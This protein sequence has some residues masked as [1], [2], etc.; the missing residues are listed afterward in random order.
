MLA[1]LAT[2]YGK[3]RGLAVVDADSGRLLASRGEHIPLDGLDPDEPGSRLVG[4]A[5]G[6][7][8]LVSAAR[9]ERADGTRQLIVA[10]GPLRLPDQ[11]GGRSAYVTDAQG[12]TV[13]ASGPHAADAGLRKAVQ[14]GR[15]DVR[16]AGHRYYVIGRGEVPAGPHVRDLGLTVSTVV[17]VPA[18]TAVGDDRLRGLGAAGALL[19]VALLVTW[20]LVRYVQRPL[21]TLH[22]EARR[23]A[24]GELARPVSVRARGEAARIAGALESLRR[25][26]RG[27]TA[28][29]VRALKGRGE[30]RDQPQRSRRQKTAYRST[31]RLVLAGCATLIATWAV[32]LPLAGHGQGGQYVPPQAA[33]DQRDRTQ[34]AAD[35]IRRTLGE[36]VADLTSIAKLTAGTRVGDVLD[37]ARPR[38]GAWRSLYLVN[39]DGRILARSGHHPLDI[40]RRSALAK[41]KPGGTAVLQLNRSG[42]VPV[43]AAV[44]P[45]GDGTRKLV[46]ELTPD[47]FNGVLTRSGLGRS[48]LVDPS[49][50]IIAS[51][52]GF[53]AFRSPPA[54]GGR[55]LAATAQV[56]GAKA[57]EG[58]GWRVVTHKPLSWTRLAAYE[59]ERHAE[60]AALLALAAAGLGLG[61]LELTVLR[62]LRALDRSAQALAG[63]DRTAVIYPVHH[64][65][66]GSVARSLELIRQQLA[67]APAPEPPLPPPPADR[68][69]RPEAHREAREAHREAGSWSS[70]SAFSS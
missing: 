23:V 29:S 68:D 14:D 5:S 3:W 11:Y 63:G 44:V 58:L 7:P 26:L 6:A 18:G 34:A 67:A 21:L 12:R 20:L 4:G 52:Q 17:P 53:I 70:S 28:E 60:L 1:S 50:R 15:G 9:L 27:E 62:P 10:S 59:T 47:A 41:V 33:R 39:R 55:T 69:A 65:E 13:L 49:G 2:A 56:K 37:D 25:Q 61:W 64:D 40:D 36:T 8:R 43:A 54:P 46:G 38:H 30:L 24:R 57:V 45:V 48:W 35:R 19:A 51:N 32:A 16:R 66:V 42:R 31:L 22:Q